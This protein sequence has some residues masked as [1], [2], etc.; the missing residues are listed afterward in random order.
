MSDAMER[1][2]RIV[3]S[4]NRIRVAIVGAGKFGT[5]RAM[6]IAANS[7]SE[8]RVIADQVPETARSL[9][10]TLGCSSS[11]NWEETVT[12]E[13][14]DA[15][16]VATST[17]SLNMVSHKALAAGKHVL[18]EKPLGRNA[19]EVRPTVEMATR[20]NLCLKVG[21]NHRYHPAI[22]KAHALLSEGTIGKI[23]FLRCLY[24]HGGRK[25]YEHEWRA[26][27][28]LSGGGQLLDQGVHVLDLF[29]WFLGDFHE[30]K[31]YAP[32]LHWP[33]APAEDNIFALL[34]TGDGRVALLHASWTNWK[35]VF[36]FDVFGEKGSLSVHGLGGHYGV[37]RL[38]W[39]DRHTNGVKPE[40]HWFEYDAPDKSLEEEWKDFLDCIM[41]GRRPSSDG[42]DSMKTLQLAE[43]IYKSAQ[44][45]PGVAVPSSR[46][47]S[48]SHHRRP[49]KA[50]Y[51]DRANS[52]SRRRQ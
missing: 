32:T 27:P 43:A 50:E 40:E 14:V 34:R 18:C 21:Y 4:D 28:R 2:T 20:K 38:C 35:N 3:P 17:Q 9:A 36:T 11:T 45:T 7:G 6:A 1:K 5:K 49:L 42:L 16:V 26:D 33:I 13:D 15:V 37:E 10:E 25:G 8:I 51:G 12:R 46:Q 44:D 48:P 31:A 23:E 30:V 22:A 52:S 24:G 41:T 39:A 19:E 29:R 47:E